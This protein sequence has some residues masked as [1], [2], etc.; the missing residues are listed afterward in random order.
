MTGVTLFELYYEEPKYGEFV[1]KV[2]NTIGINKKKIENIS[3]EV[4]I[5]GGKSKSSRLY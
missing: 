1:R 5:L 4:E 3:K 2:Q